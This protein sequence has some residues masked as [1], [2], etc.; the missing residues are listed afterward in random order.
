RGSEGARRELDQVYLQDGRALAAE[1]PPT[2]V[3]KLDAVSLATSTLHLSALDPEAREAA[4]LLIYKETRG[5][6]IVG[7]FDANA[8]AVGNII[9]VSL[10]LEAAA[11][12]H[13]PRF[14]RPPL[15]HARRRR[16]QQH[17]LPPPA[18]SALLRP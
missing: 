6:D 18:I 12:V 17:P 14:H 10:L 15:P 7:L 4:L 16:R 1:V 13:A 8:D 5:A 3:D 9:R 11:D 2:L